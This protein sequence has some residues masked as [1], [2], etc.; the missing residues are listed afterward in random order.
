MV[1]GQI[2][3]RLNHADAAQSP[4]CH[5]DDSE[6]IAHRELVANTIQT[7]KTTGHIPSSSIF[8]NL[9]FADSLG[10][11]KTSLDII[12]VSGWRIDCFMVQNWSGKICRDESGDTFTVESSSKTKQIPD[13][14]SEANRRAALVKTYLQQSGV[15]LKDK[16]VIGRLALLND[17]LEDGSENKTIFNNPAVIRDIKQF[18]VAYINSWFWTF[19]DPL[20]YSLFSGSIS[21]A[22]LTKIHVALAK[23]GTFDIAFLT[24]GR[25]IIGDFIGS[26]VIS[27]DRKLVEEIQ[28]ENTSLGISG[29]A[30]SVFG[31]FPEVS[32][33]LWRRGGQGWWFRDKHSTILIPY[34]QTLRFKISGEHQDSV[35]PINEIVKIIISK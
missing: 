7:L 33:I 8:S 18:S 4:T 23:L 27:I 19:A 30:K 12:V 31:F 25:K 29:R 26:G 16:H 17:E 34:N 21:Y 24:G 1:F 10:Q 20:I 9:R 15:A 22:Q 6:T 2:V 28:I 5:T 11:G 3:D 13:P 14:I 32:C 35:I